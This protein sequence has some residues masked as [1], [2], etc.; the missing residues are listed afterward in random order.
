M[1]HNVAQ[2]I[3]GISPPPLGGLENL[4]NCYF[5]IYFK[6]VS[7]RLPIFHSEVHQLEFT[8]HLLK[9]LVEA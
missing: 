1:D 3:D 9:M 8:H 5:L 7:F 2:G 4:N 6:W